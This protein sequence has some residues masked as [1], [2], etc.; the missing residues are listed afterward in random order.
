MLHITDQTQ[1][2][3]EDP[4]LGFHIFDYGRYLLSI[5]TLG[6]V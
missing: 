2:I 1:K 4:K 5:N 6:R 3:N